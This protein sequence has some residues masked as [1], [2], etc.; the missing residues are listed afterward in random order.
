MNETLR[1]YTWCFFEMRATI[2]NIADEDVI[3]CLQNGLFSK[4]MY[5]NFRHNRPTTAV[6][7]RDMMA[8]WADQEDEENDYF[9]SETA[10]SRATAT[11]TSIRASGTTR[12]TLE[13]ASQTKKSWLLSAIHVARNLGT[14][15]R[16]L[17]KFCT[18]NARCT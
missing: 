9:P 15:T 7:L 10:I 13:S 6:E 11:A 16:S 3:C 1:F 17:R 5:H 18:N 8:Q 12:G 14:M 4:H 2:A